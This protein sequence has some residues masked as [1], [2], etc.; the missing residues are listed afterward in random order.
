MSDKYS[1]ATKPEGFLMTGICSSSLYMVIKWYL[2][3]GFITWIPKGKAVILVW[4]FQV[5]PVLAGLF[6]YFLCYNMIQHAGSEI[7][8]AVGV[9]W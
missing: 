1:Q 8:L 9:W 5:N 4:M 2:H 3:A 7:F 6:V